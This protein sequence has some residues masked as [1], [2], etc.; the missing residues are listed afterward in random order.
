[1]LVCNL[2]APCD[3]HADVVLQFAKAMHSAAKEVVVMGMPLR[4][5]VGIHTAS[6]VGG[7]VS[8]CASPLAVPLSHSPL[9]D[10]HRL[11]TSA[12]NSAYLATRCVASIV[13]SHPHSSLTRGRAR[14]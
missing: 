6:A 8:A 1:M 12:H 10:V 13:P 3:N 7:V 4:I 2:E 11:A 14:R 9:R 5:R